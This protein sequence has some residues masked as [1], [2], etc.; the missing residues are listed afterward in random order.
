MPRVNINVVLVSFFSS[1]STCTIMK[2][3]Q[4]ISISSWFVNSNFSDSL[5]HTLEHH[6]E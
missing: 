1:Q 2:L 5:L 3:A 4:F 6:G